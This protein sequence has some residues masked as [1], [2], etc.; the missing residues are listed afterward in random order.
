MEGVWES[1]EEKV[2]KMTE[3]GTKDRGLAESS[4]RGE[5]RPWG[6]GRARLERRK[7][8]LFRALNEGRR[9]NQETKEE[10]KLNQE[11]EPWHATSLYREPV[12]QLNNVMNYIINHLEKI[13]IFFEKI[14]SREVIY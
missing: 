5:G 4:W 1:E 6:H 13:R 10:E 7:G 3:N 11:T 12:I 14:R 8:H 2:E 9:R